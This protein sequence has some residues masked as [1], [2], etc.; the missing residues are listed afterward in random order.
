MSDG[1]IGIGTLTPSTALEIDASQIIMRNGSSNGNLRIQYLYGSSVMLEPTVNF[2]GYLGY[3]NYWMQLKARHLYFFND[4][5]Y[6]DLRIKEDVKKLNNS[7]S[8]V[9]R[10]NGVK[11]KLKP[12]YCS[13]ETDISKN[14]KQREQFG[15]IAQDL[16]KIIPEA[17]SY[18]STA[19]LYAIS[20]SRI[21]PLLVEA[22]KEM[23]TE[24]V[25]LQTEFENL[26]LKLEDLVGNEFDEIHETSSRNPELLNEIGEAFL[27][28]NQP[29]PFNENTIINFYLESAVRQA[30]LHI[31]DMQ[32]R[33]IRTLDIS[34]RNNG[35]IVISANELH[36]GVYYYSLIADGRRI[37]TR[38]MILTD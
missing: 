28:Q 7:L 24:Y 8:K 26:R 12:E 17:V 11:Y 37:D 16:K 3:N 31:Y 10:M 22:I 30:V 4:H 15:F 6:S 33:R 27:E 34:D 9:L 5:Y 29:N 18:D 13:D 32:G 25:N 2:N 19:K 1:K 35:T 14:G 20:Y 36:P 38:Q 23:N 21:I